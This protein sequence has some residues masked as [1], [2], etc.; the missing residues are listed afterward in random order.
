MVAMKENYQN[1]EYLVETD[2]L[3]QNLE[4][5]DLR[6]FD[7]SVRV[8]PN[9]DSEQRQ[10]IPFIYLS[11]RTNFELGHIPGAGFID[12]PG[13]LSDPLSNM[14]LML[15]AEQQFTE[16]MSRHGIGDDNRVVLYSASEPNWAARV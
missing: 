1:P 10:Q 4:S 5:E 13:E 16:I 6:I 3:E 14:P 7:C 11:G 8:L 2:W 15:P 12:V 9:P